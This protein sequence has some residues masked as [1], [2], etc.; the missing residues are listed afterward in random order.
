MAYRDAEA[1]VKLAARAADMTAHHDPGVLNT[2]A[3]ALAALG[4]FDQ[5]VARAEAAADLAARSGDMALADS[6]RARLQL[7]RRRVAY[8]DRSLTK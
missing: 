4:R 5:A 7:Y 3:A 2:Y 6:I 1:A 8:V